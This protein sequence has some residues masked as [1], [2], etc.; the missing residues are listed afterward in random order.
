MTTQEM[1]NAYAILRGAKVTKMD[2]AD[3]FRVVKAMRPNTPKGSATRLSPAQAAR[4][5]ASIARPIPSHFFFFKAGTSR[6]TR[7]QGAENCLQMARPPA[8]GG[9]ATVPLIIKV[10]HTDVK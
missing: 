5:R 4:T 9:A 10:R 6:I 1:V 7:R 2:D 3:K 8:G